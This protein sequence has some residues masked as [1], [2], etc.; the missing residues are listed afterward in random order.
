MRTYPANIIIPALMSII[1]TDK[2][3]K[4]SYFNDYEDWIKLSPIYKSKLIYKPSYV[5]GKISHIMCSPKGLLFFMNKL[6]VGHS[7]GNKRYINITNNY[8]RFETRNIRWETFPFDLVKLEEKCR[9]LTKKL[10]GSTS[11]RVLIPIPES[12]KY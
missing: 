9:E 1:D 10:P 4:F 8:Y 7:R 11:G 2:Y 6:W 12:T 3:V 5:K